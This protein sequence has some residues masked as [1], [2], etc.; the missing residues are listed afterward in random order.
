MR[1]GGWDVAMHLAKTA[2]RAMFSRN[3]APARRFRN[4]LAL[5]LTFVLLSI[6]AVSVAVVAVVHWRVAPASSGR[7]G[8]GT[9]ALP[10]FV[11]AGEDRTR[12]PVP[13]DRLASE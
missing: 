5:V 2:E 6:S 12:T 7:L 9:S 10:G 3:P 13:S 8:L 11:H 4:L 1:L